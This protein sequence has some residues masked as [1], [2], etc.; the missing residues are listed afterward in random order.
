[1]AILL[2]LLL[3]AV[4][5]APATAADV[6]VDVTD[7]QFTP[8]E[9]RIEVG[10][11]VVWRFLDAGH[12]ATSEP[13]Q[14]ESWDS[15]Y[16]LQGATYARIFTRP[17]RFQYVCTPHA[18][19]PMRGVIQVGADEP[20]VETLEA[21]RP[22]RRGRGV[23][24]GFRLGEPATVTY[25]LRGPSRRTVRRGRLDAG[26]HRITLRRLERGR[27]RGALRLV[28]DFGDTTARS[29]RFRIGQGRASR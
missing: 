23:T 21:F 25:R 1:M 12:T 22:T 29:H 8:E 19:F 20:A 13:G 11:R 9:T 18:S 26:E 2:A 27:Y 3:F 5:A 24:I 4:L 15:G 10:D 14:A 16:P 6:T 17:G 28:D 7:F